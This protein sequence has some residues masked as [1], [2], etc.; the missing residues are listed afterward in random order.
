VTARVVGAIA[1]RLELAEIESAKCKPTESLDAYD[2]YLRGLAN[3]YKWTREG[4]DQALGLFYEAIER[5]PDFSAAYAAAAGCF[6]RRK[7]QRWIIDQEQEV[8]EAKRL[9][10][11]AVQLGKDDAMVL[12]FAGYTLA[13]VVGDLEYGAAF[14]D[15]ALLINPN[16][17]FGWLARGLVNVWLG[18]PDHAVERFAQAMRLSPIDPRTFVMQHGIAYAHFFAGRYDEALSWAKMALR[19]QPDSHG[20]LRIGAASCALA[21]RDEEAKRLIA[22][23]LEIDPALRTSNFEN[24]SK[25][26]CPAKSRPT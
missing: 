16:L 11:R 18:E 21:G 14:V 4:T 25:G 8:A 17:A 23:L 12:G 13:H 26:R 22:R 1:P 24:T 9:A 19:E 10:L 2:F 3:H 6:W 5:D 7:A 15:R 20:A